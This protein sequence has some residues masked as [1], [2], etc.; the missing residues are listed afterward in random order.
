MIKID[1]HSSV[2]LDQLALVHYGAIISP[3][4]LD[5]TY[6]R[7]QSLIGRIKKR[8]KEDIL[9]PQ[10]VRFWEYLLFNHFRNL[11]R[12]LSGRPNE[13]AKVIVEI[14]SLVGHSIMS[15]NKSYNQ[16]SLTPFGVIIKNV[17]GYENYRD[18][19]LARD[20]VDKFNLNYC[21]YC[22]I[23]KLERIKTT[24]LLT[25][26]PRTWALYQLDHFYPQSRY[27]YL[28]VSF[29]NLIP[30]CSSCNAQLKGEIDFNIIT[31]FNPFHK[32]FNDY[33]HFQLKNVVLNSCDEVTIE[34]QNIKQHVKNSIDDFVL[35]DRHNDLIT[36]KK[37]F[38]LLAALRNRSP[39]IQKSIK[40]QFQG[41]FAQA[42]ITN[43]TM[44]KS[45]GI[46]LEIRQ[47]SDYEMGKMKRDIC[48]QIGIL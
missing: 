34:I 38:D 43:D 13:L 12:I 35:I 11:E 42:D 44:L 27:P 10:R 39:N 5:G 46:P 30:G 7:S 18:N 26:Y 16:A 24:N 33:F 6:H 45:Q 2:D 48:K 47:I 28:A 8:L 20:N 19:G 3:Q 41:L 17:F 25:G 31:H 36:R 1:S 21:P 22:N 23:H 29:F 14:E 4:N 40:N 15:N 9:M 37:V 32:N